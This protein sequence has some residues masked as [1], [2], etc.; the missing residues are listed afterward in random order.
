M[1][2]C[3]S[4][5]CQATDSFLDR[6]NVEIGI[7]ISVLLDAFLFGTLFWLTSLAS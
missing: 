3:L 1:H 4:S 5:H 7:T 6:H 2:L